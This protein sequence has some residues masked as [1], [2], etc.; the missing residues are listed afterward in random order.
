MSVIS[1]RM[2]LFDQLSWLTVNQLQVYHSLLLVNRI[3]KNKEPEYLYEKLSRENIRGK[4]IIPNTHLSLA[5]KSFCWRAAEWWNK[6]PNDVRDLDVKSGLKKNIK[7][8]VSLNVPRFL[9]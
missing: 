5:R 1:H 7:A 2:D 9:D 3:R 8:W 4:I 6:L